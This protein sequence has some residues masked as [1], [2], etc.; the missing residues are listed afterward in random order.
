LFPCGVADLRL[1]RQ[2][3]C[4]IVKQTLR[5]HK[6]GD[7]SKITEADQKKLEATLKKEVTEA[8]NKLVQQIFRNLP[9]RDQP[10]EFG[11]M[12]L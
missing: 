5:N 9:D 11:M 10:A 3:S 12:A 7:D 4:G 6:S 8:C 2:N 1:K